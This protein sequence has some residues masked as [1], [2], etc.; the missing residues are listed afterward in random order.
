MATNT[1]PGRTLR[2]AYSTPVTASSESPPTPTAV[3]SSVNSF[4]FISCSIVDCLTGSMCDRRCASPSAADHDLGPGRDQG[5]GGGSLLAHRTIAADF[6]LKA[7]SAGQLDDFAYGQAD[8][9][10]NTKALGIGE[11]NL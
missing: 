9:R 8:E 5:T 6:D 3:T 10:W 11:R 7:G 2:E 1:A 4:Q